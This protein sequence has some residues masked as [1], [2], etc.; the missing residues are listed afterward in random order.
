MPANPPMVRTAKVKV[1]EEDKLQKQNQRAE[2]QRLQLQNRMASVADASD[3]SKNADENSEHEEEDID[4]FS[5]DA[6]MAELEQYDDK[7]V[8][9]I[10]LR[11]QQR[12][13]A[14]GIRELFI[15]CEVMWESCELFLLIHFYLFFQ[16]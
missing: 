4:L 15:D 7:L 10:Q 9:L 11:K 12:T 14:R 16:I 1:S 8:Q 5:T 6:S 13:G 2:Q 3:E